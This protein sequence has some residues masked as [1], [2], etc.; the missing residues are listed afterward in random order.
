MKIIDRIIQFLKWNFLYGKLGVFTGINIETYGYCNR[1][2]SFCFNNEKFLQREKGIMKENI[3][4]KIIDELSL[5]KFAGRIG[6]H[7]YG[8]PLLDKRL[9]K[10]VE[11]A[12]QKCPSC[13]LE[14]ASNV[15][16]LTEKK[17]RDL[18]NAGLNKIIATNYD[19]KENDKMLKL[20]KKYSKIIHYRNYKDINIINR[21]GGLFNYKSKYTNNPC[22][23]PSNLI[24]IDW[25]GD[26]ILCCNDHYSYFIFGNVNHNTIRDI[27]YSKRFN[28]IRAI[29]RKK[30]G[31]SQIEICKNCESTTYKKRILGILKRSIQKKIQ[32]YLRKI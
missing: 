20:A 24:N 6:L 28:K 4:Y 1:Q 7:H 2:C 12:R 16:M 26:V 30:K 19:D 13:F 3:Y 17:L 14:I 31:R 25:K 5:M 15:D 29:L 22:Y 10:F 9:V 11:Y 23:S 32:K 18:I 27:W 8:E 21:A